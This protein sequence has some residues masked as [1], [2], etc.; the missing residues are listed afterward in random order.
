MKVTIYDLID[1][2]TDPKFQ[3]IEVYSLDKEATVYEGTLGDEVLYDE[4]GAYEVRSIDTLFRP[5][6]VIVINID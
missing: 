4:F 3:H 1:L 5:S 6:D 2:F